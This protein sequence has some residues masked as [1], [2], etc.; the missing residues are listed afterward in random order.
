MVNTLME[1]GLSLSEVKNLTDNEYIMIL[2]T[3]IA[4]KEKEAD[5]LKEQSAAHS[6]PPNF[7]RSPRGLY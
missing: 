7:N 6:A 5:K 4:I 2:A 3:K 1:M